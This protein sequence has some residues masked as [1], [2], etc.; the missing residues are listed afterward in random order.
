VVVKRGGQDVALEL[1]L[2]TRPGA[3]R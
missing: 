3:A 1:T 2:A